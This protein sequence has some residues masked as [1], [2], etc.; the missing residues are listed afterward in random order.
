MEENQRLI[1]PKKECGESQNQKSK[2]DAGKQNK[3]LHK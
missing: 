2:Q 1:S 3:E